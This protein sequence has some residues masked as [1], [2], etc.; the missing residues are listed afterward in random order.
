MTWVLGGLLGVTGGMVVPMTFG[1]PSP[2]LWHLVVLM[3]LCRLVLAISCAAR[4][5][6]KHVGWSS[7]SRTVCLAW[8]IGG[9]GTYAGA[10]GF[11][12]S[13]RRCCTVD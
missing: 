13:V 9:D 5:C 10:A 8:G 2:G 4:A 3:W 6:D 11:Y 1:P 7:S 12:Q